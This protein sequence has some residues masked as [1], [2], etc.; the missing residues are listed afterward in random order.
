MEYINKMDIEDV[1]RRVELAT[2]IEEYGVKIDID[3]FIVDLPVIIWTLN[4]KEKLD[5]LK[6]KLYAPTTL[7]EVKYID[8]MDIE[9]IRRWVES[10]TKLEEY[11]VKIESHGFWWTDL[12]SA[13]NW[14]LRSEEL[15]EKLD[16][17][18]W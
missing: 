2:K 18:K 14:I 6:W 17:L 9:E 11:G 10:A 1:K 5:L 7:S 15:K 13:G 12:K 3:E 16:L 4:L 8:E